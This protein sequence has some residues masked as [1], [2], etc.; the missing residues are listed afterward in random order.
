MNYYEEMVG[1]VPHV[2]LVHLDLLGPDPVLDRGPGQVGHAEKNDDVCRRRAHLA[3]VDLE[4][5]RRGR[6][7]VGIGG[8]RVGGRVGARAV[9]EA[10][11]AVGGG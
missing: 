6:V 7:G 8:R 3:P 1:R 11:E 2:L 4:V 10:A 5:L 9:D